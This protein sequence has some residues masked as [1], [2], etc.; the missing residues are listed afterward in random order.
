MSMGDTSKNHKEMHPREWIHECARDCKTV[1]WPSKCNVFL[2]PATFVTVT[3]TNILTCLIAAIDAGICTHNHSV[4]TQKQPYRERHRTSGC[5]HN[6][7]SWNW[8]A[9]HLAR[10]AEKA[11]KADIVISG[12]GTNVSNTNPS[13]KNK[14]WK[15][16]DLVL[17]QHISTHNFAWCNIWGLLFAG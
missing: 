1:P 16:V 14:N 17:G 15:Q 3:A 2:F 12:L 13:W 5:C 9:K 11:Q 8:L 7:N 10:R 6:K 4:I